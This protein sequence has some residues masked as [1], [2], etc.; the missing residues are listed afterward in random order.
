MK[1]IQVV[2]AITGAG[3]YLAESLRVMKGIRSAYDIDLTVLVSKNAEIVLKMYKLWDD[4]QSSFEKIKVERGSNQPFVA[5]PLQVGR[6]SLFLI[7]PATANTV[8]K[9]AYGIADSLVTNCVSQA[10]KG[11]MQVHIYPVDQEL[12]SLETDVPGGKKIT[13]STRKIDVENVE[14]LRNMEGIIILKHP[15]E[16]ESVVGSVANAR[17]G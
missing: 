1:P 16:M 3:D 6:Y 15:G 10:I 13:I 2:W 9:I 11:G 17:T 7:S 14:R 12:G 4:L 8:A 5:G